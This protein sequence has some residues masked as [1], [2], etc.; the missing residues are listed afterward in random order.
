MC[1]QIYVS[2]WSECNPWRR[3]VWGSCL[4]RESCW[5][6]KACKLKAQGRIQTPMVFRPGVIFTSQGKRDLANVINVNY[7]LTLREGDYARLSGGLSE[8]TW[9]LKQKRKQRNLWRRKD[10]KEPQKIALF[11]IMC[12]NSILQYLF[13]CNPLSWSLFLGNSSY[14]LFAFL[15]PLSHFTLSLV[16][17][18]TDLLNK[19]SSSKSLSQG[20]LLPET[21]TKTTMFN[22]HSH[23]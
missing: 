2:F 14:P 17:P 18:R 20:L 21:K 19:W 1:L 8:V 13:T 16:F 6:W 12:E 5:P 15:T 4:P 11:S 23:S 9:T 3:G 7:L 22:T 10:L